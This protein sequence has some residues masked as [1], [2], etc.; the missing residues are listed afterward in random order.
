MEIFL[1]KPRK[2]VV[3][4]LSSKEKTAFRDFRYYI[5]EKVGETPMRKHSYLLR[6][7]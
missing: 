2:C 7:R 1:L 6:I 5:Q 4:E 3:V